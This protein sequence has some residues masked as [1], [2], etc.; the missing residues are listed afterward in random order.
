VIIGWLEAVLCFSGAG[1]DLEQFLEIKLTVMCF[2]EVFRGRGH[3]WG[4]QKSKGL[5][6]I[7]EYHE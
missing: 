2:L 6:I 3:Y 7:L 4:P 1:P 5:G